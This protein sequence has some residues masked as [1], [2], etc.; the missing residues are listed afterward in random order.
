[1]KAVSFLIKLTHITQK[2]RNKI[3]TGK[4]DYVKVFICRTKHSKKNKWS[5]QKINYSF[6]YKL[7]VLVLVIFFQGRKSGK[8]HKL[9][10][11]ALTIY[12]LAFLSWQFRLGSAEQSFCWSLLSSLKHSHSQLLGRSLMGLKVTPPKGPHSWQY[13]VISHPEKLAWLL[14]SLFKVARDDRD[15]LLKPC[16]KSYTVSSFHNL[17]VWASHKTSPDSRHGETRLHLL[18][19]KATWNLGSFLNTITHLIHIYNTMSINQIFKR[20]L[21]KRQ[22]I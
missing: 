15:V 6:Y 16:S 3:R 1:M 18:M 17:L 8:A 4:F 20:Q 22:W 7:I 14:P 10:T 19:G 2:P 11:W 21:T 12:L 13:L 5:T 9:M